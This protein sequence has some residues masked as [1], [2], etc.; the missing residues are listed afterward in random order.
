MAAAWSSRGTSD[1]ELLT[2]IW[3]LKNNYRINISN[4]L[5]INYN[6]FSHILYTVALNYASFVSHLPVLLNLS[7][8]TGKSGKCAWLLH[9]LVK[10]TWKQT[11]W[12]LSGRTGT[13]TT[14]SMFPSS[15]SWTYYLICMF[16]CFVCL[17]VCFYYITFKS[18]HVSLRTQHIPPLGI[19]NPH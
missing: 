12:M 18:I 3:H 2:P 16:V 19:S 10:A 13:F 17:C 1:T 6:Y 7:A 8:L 14:G 9:N 15:V 5:L 4:W 11:D